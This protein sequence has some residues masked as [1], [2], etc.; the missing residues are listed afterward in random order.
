MNNL[1]L[2]LILGLFLFGCTQNITVVHTE[3]TAEDV[4]DTEQSPTNDIKAD[5]E[6]PI[7]PL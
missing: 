7:K 1:C 2:S 4:V 6:V 3:G 5:L